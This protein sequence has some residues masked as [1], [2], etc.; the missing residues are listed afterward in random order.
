MQARRLRYDGAVSA[1]GRIAS[2]RGRGVPY[3]LPERQCAFRAGLSARQARDSRSTHVNVILVSLDTL[4]PDRLGCYGHFRP[5]SPNIDRVASQGALFTRCF[6]PHIPTYPGHTTLFTGRDVYAHGV[7]GQSGAFEPPRDIPL[8]AEILQARGYYTGAADNL[9]KWFTRGIEHVE[10]YSWDTSAKRDWRKGEAVAEASIRIIER[11]ASQTKPF[12]LFLHFWDPHTPYLPPAPFDR[13]YYQGDEKDPANDSMAD[14]WAFEPFKWYFH[15]WMPGVTDIE[16]P[17]AQYDA[18]IAYMDCCLARVLTRLEELDLVRDTLVVLT[19]DHGEELDEH[20][21][22]FDHHGLYDTNVRIPLIIR[23]PG[24]IPDGVRIGGLVRSLDVLPTILDLA[25]IEPPECD[26]ASMVPLIETAGCG[27]DRGTCDEIHLT[28]NTWMKKRGIRTA[29]WKLIRALEP[30]PHGFPSLELYRLTDDPEEQRNLAEEHPDVAAE[31]EAR[32]DAHIARRV[33]AVG[34]PDPI[35][36][37][38]VPLKRVGKMQESDPGKAPSAV[39][40]S[41]LKDGDFIGY[42]RDEQMP[43]KGTA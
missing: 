30:D 7:T 37:Q 1:V 22:W 17:K 5:T 29:T 24:T 35:P 31:L 38:P 18:E 20:G 15:E 14:L 27:N 19:A 4:R 8:I 11:A 2:V 26:G 3:A 43:A 9:G 36:I 39:G 25:G 13:M 42:V 40:D 41:K 12:F 33:A 6:S 34:R 10:S 23:L 32:M 28:E 21:C 16:F